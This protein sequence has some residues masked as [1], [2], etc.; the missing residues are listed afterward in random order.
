MKSNN[1][2]L[3]DHMQQLRSRTKFPTDP[4]CCL[5]PCPWENDLEDCGFHCCVAHCCCGPCI[6]YEAMHM[7]PGLNQ[8]K[9]FNAC[10]RVDCAFYTTV[11]ASVLACT[12]ASLPQWW[13][14]PVVSP[15]VSLTA[16]SFRAIV[17]K[18]LN[19]F[20]YGKVGG[21]LFC[22][23]CLHYFCGP[24]ALVQETNA[25]M[26]WSSEAHARKVK[27]GTP[28]KCECCKFVDEKGDVVDL[29]PLP[30]EFSPVSMEP[31]VNAPS[32]IQMM[33]R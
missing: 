21:N 3:N 28:W 11:V 29:R 18:D 4:F 19:T 6:W 7:V 25:L 24:C 33:V 8:I 27:Y 2:V 31:S 15:V 14:L 12:S 13:I 30:P 1:G 23:G 32:M 26:V 10:G 20:L 16:A 22:G 5:C 9:V 17:R